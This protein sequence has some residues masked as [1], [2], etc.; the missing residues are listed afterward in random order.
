M[1]DTADTLGAQ[2]SGPVIYRSDETPFSSD[3]EPIKSY[4]IEIDMT[5]PARPLQRHVWTHDDGS[6][7]CEEWIPGPRWSFADLERLRF[8]RVVFVPQA[9]PPDDLEPTEHAKDVLAAIGAE[10]AR[11]ITR[12]GFSIEHDDAHRHGELLHAAA[13]YAINVGIAQKY[14]EKRMDA[15]EFDAC[16]R[17]TPV[18]R[19]WPLADSW[20]KPKG[21]RHDLIVAAA[22]LVAEIER[23]DREEA[24]R[25]H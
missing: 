15:D 17:E 24:K 16:I 4:H 12:E 21:A 19:F 20:W 9:P 11:Q 2:Q 5:D 3:G 1:V 23:I 18:P 10:R 6:V 25:R 13:A 22:L 14:R 8:K 7:H